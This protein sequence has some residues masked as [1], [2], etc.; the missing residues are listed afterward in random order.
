MKGAVLIDARCLQGPSARRGIGR[1]ASGL[2]GGLVAA[3]FEF[4]VMVDAGLPE[5]ELPARIERVHGVRRR[6]HGRFAGY[7]D[8]VALVS[9]LRELRPALF[10]AL[11]LT[12]PA[13]SPCP[14]AV[15]V[16][17]LIPWAFGGWRMAGERLRFRNAKRNLPRAELVFAVSES[18][19]RDVDRF[20]GVDP[21]RVKVVAEGLDSVF[22]PRPDAAAR[23]GE[24][25]QQRRPYYLFVGALDVRKDPRGLLRAWQVAK[26]AGA[27]ADLLIAGEPGRQAP[28]D[29][30][31][32]RLL[33]QVTDDELADLLSAAAGLIYPSLYEGFGLP[34]LEAMGCGCPVAAY[35]NSSLPEVVGEG[36]VLVPNRDVEGLGRAAARFLL[37]PAHR[38]TIV[39]AG[40]RQAARFTW[41][42]AA[43][44]TIEGY[45][46]LGQTPIIR[47]S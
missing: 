45:R 31:P 7:E 15:T 3:G 4:E 47:R 21:V 5:P 6:T 36:G 40:A 35:A 25:W 42:E 20:A 33:G 2:L 9:E 30:G 19:A 13:R 29:M 17:D 23:V 26:A 37:D 32:A 46:E 39:A 22:R 12:L 38:A 44:R 10:H 34:P 18:T 43:R 1:Y 14:V 27:D 41:A 16:H 8:S 11:T 24:R 28:A